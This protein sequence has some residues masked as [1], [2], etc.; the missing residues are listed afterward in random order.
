LAIRLND[1]QYVRENEPYRNREPELALLLHWA[2]MWASRQEKS[3]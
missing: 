2:D 3:E 1:G